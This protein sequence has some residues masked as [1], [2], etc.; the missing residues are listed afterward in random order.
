MIIIKK[1]ICLLRPALIYK[2]GAILRGVMVGPLAIPLCEI[3]KFFDL[4]MQ[5]FLIP[6]PIF[7]ELT[8]GRRVP[9]P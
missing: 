3:W 4:E 1:S 9:L 7:A 5:S 2:R 8:R 6:E